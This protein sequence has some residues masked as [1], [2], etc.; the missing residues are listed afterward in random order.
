MI[1]DVVLPDLLPNKPV[2]FLCCKICKVLLGKGDFFTLLRGFQENQQTGVILGE[3]APLE[4]R[5]RFCLV[6]YV[7]VTGMKSTSI[8]WR[9]RGN[10]PHPPPKKNKVKWDW[11]YTS[12]L[13]KTPWFH[14]FSTSSAFFVQSHPSRL[15]YPLGIAKYHC[16]PPIVSVSYK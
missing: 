12:G 10:V 1:Q 15:G 7:K 8:L 2:H 11:H 9:Q 6:L 16:S 13:R 5:R 3:N 4:Q 14:Q